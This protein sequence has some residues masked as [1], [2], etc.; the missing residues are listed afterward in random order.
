MKNNEESN[1]IINEKWA[2]TNLPIKGKTILIAE[3]EHHI[4]EIIKINLSM[5]GCII[6]LAK[7]GREALE[8]ASQTVPDL[9]ITD[10]MMPDMDGIEL[11]LTLRE[12]ES[13]EKVPVI[14]ISVK[15][16]AEDL[17]TASLLGVDDYITKPF[18]P[19]YLM[20]KVRKVLGE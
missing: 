3:D 9:I 16:Q 20:K 4:R 19:A 14:M 5:E 6:L 18:D 17:K 15:S 10:I 1:N 13:T 8:I 2:E 7:N 12:K 11:F